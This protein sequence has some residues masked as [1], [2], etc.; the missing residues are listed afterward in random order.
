[1][2][3]C[4]N[5]LQE[6]ETAPEKI[7]EAGN[8]ENRINFDEKA[9]S[10]D[11]IE[12]VTNSCCQRQQRKQSISTVNFRMVKCKCKELLFSQELS[13]EERWLE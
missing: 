7:V 8:Q 1:M 3:L 6:L 10:S 9:R 4:K 2:L 13:N 12:Q 5:Q 11:G